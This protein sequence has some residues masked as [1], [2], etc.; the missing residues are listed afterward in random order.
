MLVTLYAGLTAFWAP[1][2]RILGPAL[3]PLGQAT[4]YVFVMHVAF[5]LVVANVPLL[6]QGRVLPGTLAHALILVAL[7]L[8]VRRRFLFNIV[9]R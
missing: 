1:V 7:W 5:A 4:L 6:E 9:P 8:M 3:I 2:R